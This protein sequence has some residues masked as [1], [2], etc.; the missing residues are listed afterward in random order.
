MRSG[1]IKKKKST[2]NKRKGK[3]KKKEAYKKEKKMN[4]Q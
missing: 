4:I 2:E 1:K 3:T